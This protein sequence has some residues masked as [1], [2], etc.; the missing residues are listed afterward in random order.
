MLRMV[1]L[2]MWFNLSDEG[3]EEAI[4]DSYAMK[5]FM[6]FNLSAGEDVYKRQIVDLPAPER[7]IMATNSLCSIFRF[8]S[9]SAVKPFG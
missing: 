8:M 4:Y 2:Q 3:V 9:F 1:M 5:S 7:P 6:G